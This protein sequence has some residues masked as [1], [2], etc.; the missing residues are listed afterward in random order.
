MAKQIASAAFYSVDTAMLTTDAG[1]HVT[2]GSR[3]REVLRVDFLRKRF[4]PSE[5]ICKK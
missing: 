1:Q 2:I 4:V 5:E 3:L